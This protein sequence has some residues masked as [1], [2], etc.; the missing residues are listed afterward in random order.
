MKWRRTRGL[1]GHQMGQSA[2]PPGRVW[3]SC[4]E[5]EDVIGAWGPVEFPV[6]QLASASAH[7]RRPL[8]FASL[9]IPS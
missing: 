1:E 3:Q 2:K 8:P 7:F 6:A 9:N 4:G 5:R